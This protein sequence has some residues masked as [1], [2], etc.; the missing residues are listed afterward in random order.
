MIENNLKK[1]QVKSVEKES[2]SKHILNQNRDNMIKIRKNNSK[3]NTSN[4]N[5]NKGEYINKNCDKL[6]LDKNN[7]KI[8][9]N[10]EHIKEDSKQSNRFDKL[11]NIIEKGGNHKV[12][13]LDKVSKNNI[14]EVIKVDNYKEYNKMIEPSSSSQNGCCLI[15]WLLILFEFNLTFDLRNIGLKDFQ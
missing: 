10:I 14:I 11:G 12:T 4:S 3:L 2:K 5:K 1:K 6:L 13:F 15:E 7:I 9:K 8:I